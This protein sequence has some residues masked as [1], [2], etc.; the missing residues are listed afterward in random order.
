MTFKAPLRGSSR[1][2]EMRLHLQPAEHSSFCSCQDSFSLVEMLAEC[3]VPLKYTIT[4]S[5]TEHKPW[6]DA[7]FMPKRIKSIL[8]PHVILIEMFTIDALN[9]FF[10]TFLASFASFDSAAWSQCLSHLPVSLRYNYARQHLIRTFSL[11][12]REKNASNQ[13]GLRIA[14]LGD[15]M[16]WRSAE[17]YHT[18]QRIEK[19]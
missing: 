19:L 12:L 11:G 9:M 3:L 6:F 14:D 5:T 4:I 13:W 18:T 1:A 15:A 16:S 7:L 17:S 2:F 10:L 8:R